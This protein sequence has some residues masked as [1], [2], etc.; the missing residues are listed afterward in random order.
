MVNELN[1]HVTRTAE[2][3]CFNSCTCSCRLAKPTCQWV[4][5]E[6]PSSPV[7]LAYGQWIKSACHA[8]SRG[9]VLQQLHL[10]L[11]TGIPLMKS[12]TLR[13]KFMTKVHKIVWSVQNSLCKYMTAIMRNGQWHRNNVLQR[14]CSLLYN[15]P[16][17][18]SWETITGK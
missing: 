15:K 7:T 18:C 11:P 14:G 5:C 1:Q 2:G 10:Q 17:L 4:T 3:V 12:N 13:V 6:W 8:D 16:L 9:S